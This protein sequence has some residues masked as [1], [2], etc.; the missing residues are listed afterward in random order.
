LAAE[1]S[2]VTTFCLQA[3]KLVSEG[4]DTAVADVLDALAEGVSGAQ[5]TGGPTGETV[6]VLSEHHAGRLG[7]A[8]TRDDVVA[9][10]VEHAERSGGSAL[11]ASRE[12]VFILAGGGIGNYSSAIPMWP[13]GT[14]PQTVRIEH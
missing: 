10:L 14:P 7:E 8:H 1:H 9:Y 12:E 11:F 2:A 3:P 13:R 6:V 5:A 4:N